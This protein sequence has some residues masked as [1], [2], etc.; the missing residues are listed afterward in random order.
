[1]L[2]P[3]C[4]NNMYFLEIISVTILTNFRG[5]N[6]F[7]IIY[8]TIIHTQKSGYSLSS[9]LWNFTKWIH[10]CNQQPDQENR[11]SSLSRSILYSL[12]ITACPL[13]PRITSSLTFNTTNY[14]Y[15]FLNFLYTESYTRVVFCASFCSTLWD[16][17]MLLRYL[18][19]NHSHA[20]NYCMTMPQFFIHS[21]GDVYFFTVLCYF[22]FESYC[23][24]WF[25]T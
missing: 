7:N 9:S 19:F 20:M 13:W 5:T 21:A 3:T 4:L 8:W 12:L 23:Y 16:S 6:N 22:Q 1:M 17:P 2:H 18:H 24:G 11:P 14:F 25:W 10:L 15:L